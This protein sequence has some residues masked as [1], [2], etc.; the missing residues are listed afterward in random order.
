MAKKGLGRGLDSLLADNAI[1]EKVSEGGITTLKISDIE[2]NR[3]QARKQFDEAPLL[4]LADSIGKHGVL[5]PISVRKKSNG[6]YEIIAGERRWRASK[7]AGLNE[8]PVII[9]EADDKLATEL[10]LIENLQRENLNAAEEARGYR[11]LM[12]RFGLTQEEAAERVGKSRTA[13]ANLL[14]ILKL[15][16][17]ILNLIETGELSYGHARTLIPLTQ[18]C[19]ED[20]LLKHAEYVIKSG[21]S[22]RQTEQYVKSAFEKN[23][24]PEI[25]EESAVTK[26]YYKKIEND[27][28]DRLGRKASIRRDADGKGK[29]TI[30]FSDSEDLE[31]LL[32]TVCGNDFFNNE[33]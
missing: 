11:D 33:D 18:I 24:T 20:E 27:I 8:I 6:Y 5:Q 1:D 30:S 10:S 12:E 21:M 29:L 14:R 25:D 7:I 22:V 15:P 26:A 23:K 31:E 13:V 17:C 16:D 28:C 32:K 3:G 4:E 19:D 9:H 2:P